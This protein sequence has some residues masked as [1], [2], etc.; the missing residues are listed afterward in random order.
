MP[1]GQGEPGRNGGAKAVMMASASARNGLGGE[2]DGIGQNSSIIRG[3]Q[4]LE[5]QILNAGN[6]ITIDKTNQIS[7]DPKYKYQL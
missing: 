5:Q 6:D 1:A 2:F 4:N 3:N 7:T